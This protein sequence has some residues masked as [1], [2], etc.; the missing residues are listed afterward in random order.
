MTVS[1]RALALGGFGFGV[2]QIALFGLTL[3]VPGQPEPDVVPGYQLSMSSYH[4]VESGIVVPQ[5]TVSGLDPQFDPAPVWIPAQ[6][7]F[8][9][10]DAGLV[11]AQHVPTGVEPQPDP[12][13]LFRHRG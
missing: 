10:V 2:R 1:P 6:G 4:H 3:F 9:R 11:A 12:P 13:R 8:H 7:S 5:H